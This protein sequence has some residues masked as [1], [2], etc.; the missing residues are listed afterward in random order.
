M[1]TAIS[2]PVIGR[3]G[4]AIRPANRPTRQRGGSP[5][6][7]L[8]RHASDK[9]TVPCPSVPLLHRHRVSDLIQS[10]TAGR[11]T[12]VCGPTGS[13]KTVACAM[14]AA[15]T[16]STGNVAWVSL[17]PGDRQAGRL[18]AH[19][20]AALAGTEAMPDDLAD[21]F[22]EPAERGFGLRLADVAKQLDQ[23]VTLVLDDVQELAGSEP[24]AELDLLVR[25]GPPNLRLVLAGRHLAGLGVA[26]LRVDGE[27]A[28][29]GA[30][31][32]ACTPAETQAYFEML[33]VEL[34]PDQLDELLGRT[35]G[36]ITGLRLAALRSETAREPVAPSRIS[37]DEPLVADYLRDEIMTTLPADRR[38]F[39]LRTCVVDRICGDLA[40]TL[41]GGQD[42]AVILDHLCRENVLVRRV[43][44]GGGARCDYEYH[45]LLLD[46]LRAELRREFPGQ[47]TELTGKAARWQAR[48][49]R[50]V[51]ALKNAVMAGDWD[52]AATVL[53]QVG[54]ELLLPGQAAI[55][56]PILATFPASRYTADAAVAGALAAA[57]LRTGDSYATELHL[58][59]AEAALEQCPDQQRAVIATWLKAL[60]LMQS[61]ARGAADTELIRQATGMAGTIAPTTSG[62][63]E[64]HALALLW[65]AAGIAALANL[66]ITEARDAFAQAGHYLPSGPSDGFRREFTARTIAWR[67]VAEAMYGDLRAADDLLA[68]PTLDEVAEADPLPGVL[69]DLASACL[70]LARDE[71]ATARR[72]LDQCAENAGN[73]GCA[74]PV[75]W[76]LA[77]M[78]RARLALCE[79]DHGAARRLITKLHYQNLNPAKGEGQRTA[80]APIGST[81]AIL[82]AEIALSE[83]N[84]AGAKL[85]L[86]RANGDRSG[87]ELSGRERSDGDRSGGD[88]SGGGRASLLLTSA[89]IL[90]ADGDSRAALAKAEGCLTDSATDA[91]M[92]DRVGAL[93]LAAIARRRLGQTDQAADQLGYALTLAEPHREY[94]SFLDGGSAARSA[95]AVLIRP[96]SQGAATA[97]RILQR[98]DTRPTRPADAPAAVPLT[99]SELAVLRFLPTHMTNQ[100]IAEALFLSINTVKTHLR[101][102]YRKLGVTTRR[103]AISTAARLGLL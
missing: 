30:D 102:V 25:H 6:Q 52:F 36:W 91:T 21:S 48:N 78:T 75:L 61:T 42:G 2:E 8:G 53:A 44:G 79:N 51:P 28:E 10:A 1:T 83:G 85:A 26:K 96:A 4:R 15:R 34:P 57:G 38:H 23:P 68:D 17:D 46:L 59:N 99:G 40:D 12:L 37:G 22:A 29:I 97:A 95:L 71:T 80:A 100:E 27:L 5:H 64:H 98:F 60:T 49:H 56:E 47:V 54:P 94:R 82:D 89:K 35:Q 39:L 18:W 63:G 14:W 73:H 93:V 90:L 7:G 33:G 11:V 87:R 66:R 88:R 45:P 77:I 19:V 92:R 84:T 43:D 50:P 55:L 41:T 13:G 101:S 86:D 103:Q 3:D 9:L 16:H 32:L 69:A 31:E 65:T 72:L 24:L 62:R 58:K 67:A 76:S 20:G 81:L 70:H 74:G